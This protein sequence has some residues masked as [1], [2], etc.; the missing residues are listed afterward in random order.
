MFTLRIAVTL[1][2]AFLIASC[3]G[4]GGGDS[5][6]S[7]VP[8]TPVTVPLLTAIANSTNN[9]SSKTF[10]VSGYYSSTGNTLTGSGTRNVSAAISAVLSGVSYLKQTTVTTG[11]ATALNATVLNLNTSGITYANPSTYATVIVD[12]TNPYSVINPYTY[13]ATVTTGDAGQFATG[14]TYSNSSKT[15][16]TGSITQSYQV[17][18]NTTTSVL[19]KVITNVYNISNA[20]TLQS[21]ST[22]SITT[23]GA[24]SLI[25]LEQYSYSVGGSTPY[26]IVETFQ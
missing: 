22:F 23:S 18:A 24:I 19:I 14:V 17:L 12:N 4:G 10:T 5:T 15:T 1:V 21:I 20:L 9:S 2:T 11:T 25:S 8:A 7:P 13:P 26:Y 16:V 6:A 3:G